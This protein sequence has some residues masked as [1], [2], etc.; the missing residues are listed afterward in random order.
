MDAVTKAEAL[1]KL[2]KVK[3]QVGYMDDIFDEDTLTQRYKEYDIHKHMSMAE[4]LWLL[5]QWTI[6]YHNKALYSKSKNMVGF[7]EDGLSPNAFYMWQSNMIF[8]HAGL[9]IEPFLNERMP[10]A[11]VFGSIG[12]TLAHEL[13]HGYDNLGHRFDGEGAVRDWWDAETKK[14]FRKR[15]KCFVEQYSR[16]KVPLDSN[17]W[18]L[19]DGNET[20]PENIA[21]NAGLKV[22]YVA[23]KIN[24]KRNKKL[25]KIRGLEDYSDEQLFFTEC[26]FK[27][28]E[29]LSDSFRLQQISFD[30][31]SPTPARVNIPMQNSK[32]FAEAFK[33]P[34]GSPMNPKDFERCTLW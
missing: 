2:R 9:M 22:A 23:M 31:H 7:D 13:M 29:K 33:C 17:K 10:M 4:V 11:M 34:V 16:V 28:C 32:E 12:H 14:E 8:F 3:V 25:L 24:I 19:I 20:L 26:A 1:K 6:N 15:S 27:R 18:T 30:I 21:D 5:E